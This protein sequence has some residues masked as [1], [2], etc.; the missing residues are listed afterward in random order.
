[1]QADSGEALSKGT[2][3]AEMV[4]Y[5]ELPFFEVNHQRAWNE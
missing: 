5:S 4:L 2:K 3:F 1:M